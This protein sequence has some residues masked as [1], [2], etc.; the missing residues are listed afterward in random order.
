[1]TPVRRRPAISHTEA[2]QGERVHALEPA[3]IGRAYGCIPEKA[4]QRDY[5]RQWHALVVGALIN[6]VAL[7]EIHLWLELGSVSNS[8]SPGGGWIQ[9]TAGN[10]E[11]HLGRTPAPVGSAAST[12]QPPR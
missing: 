8:A 5:C 2:F 12:R 9:N 11:F 4:S 6:K 7:L 10:D 1:M 3:A